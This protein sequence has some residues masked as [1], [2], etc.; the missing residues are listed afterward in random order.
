MTD[1]Q[2]ELNP[3]LL[4]SRD[5]KIGHDPNWL[6]NEFVFSLDYL[7]FLRVVDLTGL[8]DGV[9]ALLSRP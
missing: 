7:L 6:E 5:L 8:C 4:L 3:P 1:S 2:K 9:P